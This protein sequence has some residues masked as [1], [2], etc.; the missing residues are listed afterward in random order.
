MNDHKPFR[1]R[2][3]LG[4]GD[5]NARVGANAQMSEEQ[6]QLFERI[7]CRERDEQT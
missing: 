7:L 3:K 5:M 1:R 4:D 6:V 2:D